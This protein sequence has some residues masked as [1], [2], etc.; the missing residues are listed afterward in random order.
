MIKW[1]S[2]GFFLITLTII[3]GLLV[4]GGLYGYNKALGFLAARNPEI[5]VTPDS[6]AIYVADKNVIDDFIEHKDSGYSIMIPKDAKVEKKRKD[7]TIYIYGKDNLWEIAIH[8]KL[9]R[10]E[11]SLKSN[12]FIKNPKGDYY[13]LM[14]E[15]FK[16]TMNPILLFQKMSY[17]PSNTTHIKSIKTPEFFGFYVVGKTD[18]RRT[19]LYRLFD[20]ENWHNVSVRVDDSKVSHKLIQNILATLKN[21][22]TWTGESEKEEE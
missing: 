1:K 18:T 20:E 15:I 14:N 5:K 6:G 8:Q 4:A 3:I 22:E 7:P 11:D 17:L 13:V 19:E 16:A 9:I 2:L 21:D 12:R 10:Y